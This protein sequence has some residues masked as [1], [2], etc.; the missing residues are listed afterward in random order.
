MSA[1]G[2]R[3]SGTTLV[4]TLVLMSVVVLIG[5]ITFPE[6]GSALSR[7]IFEQARAGVEAD[8]RMARAQALRSGRPVTLAAAE[9]G[10]SYGWS[11]GPRRGLLG[12]LR[13]SASA[14]GITFYPD[15]SASGGLLALAD[16]RRRVGYV[17]D[18]AGGLTRDAS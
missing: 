11:E 14:S 18:A 5:T 16:G 7:S 4:E 2:D 9:D 6:L 17:I 10:A 12:D 3:Q 15:G 13:L 8:L 1:T